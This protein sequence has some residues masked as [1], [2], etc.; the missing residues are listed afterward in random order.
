MGNCWTIEPDVSV[1][2]PARDEEH[3]VRGALA[4]VAAQR[5]PTGWLEVVVVDNGS[6]DATADVVRAFAAAEPR[7]AVRL[8]AEPVA[9]LARAKNRGAAVA[10][11]RYVVFLDADSRLAP[12]LVARVMARV[13][14]GYPAGG[15]AV[16]A[17]STDWLDRGFFGLMEFG[18]RLFRIHAQMF[19]CARD[20]FARQ[21][22]F[23]EALHLA[24]DSEFL[25]RV[26]RAGVPICH[27]AASPIATSPRRLRRLPLRLAM[28]TTLVR[29]AL[30]H[31]G[32]GRRWR[33]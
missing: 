8:V 22:G 15:I 16:V 30:A 19:Y 5:W 23:D 28:V 24:E 10:R 29:W 14:A 13:A 32:V 27:I 17:D 18:K 6:A 21:G 2:I 1:V 31:A 3:Y 4:S 25:G 12:D 26:A 7:L 33:Y 9:G 11:G 20:L